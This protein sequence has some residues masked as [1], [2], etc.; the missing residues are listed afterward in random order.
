M[1]IFPENG[2]HCVVKER[3]SKSYE[4]EKTTTTTIWRY[5]LNE[6]LHRKTK[7]NNKTEEKYA[8]EG[9]KF[10]QVLVLL[11][12]TEFHQVLLGFTGFYW[13]L[14]KIYVRESIAGRGR[15]KRGRK[16]RGAKRKWKKK[17]S[18]TS[19][20]MATAPSSSKRS[21]APSRYLR[22]RSAVAV[23]LRRF[24]LGRCA[25]RSFPKPNGNEKRHRPDP[26]HPAQ[27]KENSVKTINQE[28]KTR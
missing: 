20:S 19:E 13:V 12:F 16:E 7:R 4:N 26:P 5:N 17:V 27:S 18:S 6:K 14:L 21:T 22:I 11:G 25:V 28:K 1:Q 3:R 15:T 10:D 8:N 23:L 24:P 9:S 2:G